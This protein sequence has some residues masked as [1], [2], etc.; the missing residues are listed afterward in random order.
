[1][2]TRLPY[3][4]AFSL[5]L[6]LVAPSAARAD[7]LLG[8]RYELRETGH[9]IQVRVDRGHATF[10]VQRTVD[11]PG[12]RSDQAVFFLD[13][14]PEAVATRLRSARVDAGGG[15]AWFEGE[16]LEAEL[17]RARYEELTGFGAALPK[18]PALLQWLGQG[19]LGL[20]VFPVPGLG[21]KLVEY[22][23]EMPLRYENAAYRLELPPLGTEQRS[24]VLRLSSA[25]SED[26]LTVNGVPVDGLREVVARRDLEIELRPTRPPQVSATLAEIKL[27]AD[28][29]LVRATIHAAP[30]L[31][32][33]PRH[34]ALA[35]VI[36]TSRSAAGELA[37]SLAAARAYLAHFPSADVEIVT[38][39]RRVHA[40]FGHGLA[41]RQALSLLA[42]FEPEPANGSALDEA[43]ATADGLLAHAAPAT[44]RILVLTD[45]RM[46]SRLSPERFAAT[47]LK[48]GA[49]VH[50]ATMRSGSPELSRDDASPWAE[51]PRAS[52]GL[53]WLATAEDPLD[54]GGREVFEEWAR[55]KRI[56]RLEVSGLPSDFAAPE[57]LVEGQGLE[58]FA[59]ASAP[60]G[61]L[62]LGGEL[63]S[64]P[65]RLSVAPSADEGR[66][67]AAL[68]F[69]S[70]VLGEL[71]EKEQLVLAMI[72]RAVSPVTSYLA[73]E[74]G[75]R[76]S[77]EGLQP[78][79]AA[80]GIG[81]GSGMGSGYGGA[82]GV[83]MGAGPRVDPQQFLNSAMTAAWKRCGGSKGEAEITIET[84]LSEVVDVTGVALTPPGDPRLVSCLREEAWLLELPH[85]FDDAF[86]TH[87]ARVRGG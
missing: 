39:D 37:P 29:A 48:S 30:H 5:G 59:M 67:A 51:L 11:N 62:E 27:G 52:G 65:I 38:F 64:R 76:P 25:H 6:T 58:H 41:G 22:T 50:L 19:R 85:V 21:S 82:S 26:V 15:R 78:D 53:L 24:A 55:P 14:P 79:E 86:A 56:S 72:G 69:G 18:D 46:R 34:P 75:V 54:P 32:E 57:E 31:S 2:D 66:R 49:V 3:A 77:T 45:L 12:P 70:P 35:L 74:P 80:W 16:L 68:V 36:D 17:A 23:L 33:I 87:T 60:S 71:S 42:K 83:R 7:Q 40:P 73:I 13:V 43:I 8:T 44:R 28:R 47:P 1:M 84:T 63:W 9:S 20:Q 61:K 10:V 81:S 4:A